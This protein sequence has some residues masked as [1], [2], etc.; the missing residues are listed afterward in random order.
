MN[1]YYENRDVVQDELVACHMDRV[2]G[3]YT[4]FEYI[5][6][7]RA[8]VLKNVRMATTLA[9]RLEAAVG[10]G[11]TISL[12]AFESK[13]ECYLFY[14][15]GVIQAYGIGMQ[16]GTTYTAEVPKPLN[17]MI[18]MF[19]LFC[20]ALWFLVAMWGVVIVACFLIV[21]IQLIPQALKWT[22]LVFMALLRHPVAMKIQEAYIAD[23]SRLQ[24]VRML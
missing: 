14:S 23:H 22:Q 21:G 8:G 3:L 2:E 17:G 18:V 4:V 10:T 20:I 6:F 7:R 1:S 15:E 9:S 24:N 5:E 12:Y 16:D 11:A 13:K 19:I